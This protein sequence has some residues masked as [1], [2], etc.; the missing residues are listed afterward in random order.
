VQRIKADFV[1]LALRAPLV[2]APQMVRDKDEKWLYERIN[3]IKVAPQGICVLDSTGQVLIWVQ[4][5]ERK[6]DVLKFL[7]HAVKRYRDTAG[8]RAPVVTERYMRFPTDKMNDVPDE[9]AIPAHADRHPKGTRCPAA[10]AKGRVA[11]GTVVAHLVGR[12]LDD[13]G[14]PLADVVNQ[15]HYAED[16]FALEPTVQERLGRVLTEA[17]TDRVLLPEEFARMCATH[18]HLGHIDV[19]PCLCMVPGKHENPGEWKRCAF[20]AKR[21][22]PEAGVWRLDG[23]SEVVSKVTVNG[24]G[25]HNVKLTWSGFITLKG[26]RVS[27]LLLSARGHEKLE[28]CKDLHPLIKSGKDEVAFL[29]GGRPIDVD[30][31]VRYGI[32]GEPIAAEEAIEEPAPAAGS[33]IPDEARRPL[34]EALGGPFIVFRDK[35]QEELKLSDDQK[36]KLLQEFPNH[37]QATMKVFEKIKDLQPPEREKEMQQHRRKSDEKLSAV[38]KDV[39]NAGQQERLLQLQLQQAGAFALLGQHEAFVPLKITD[40][41]RRQFME[42]VQEMHKKI[43]PVIK[44]VEKGGKPE[45]IRPRVMKI[46]KEHEA[47][48][49]ELLTEKQKKQWKDLLGKPFDLG[50]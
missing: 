16:K 12:L 18:A 31:G 39:L 19:Q 24:Q 21:A 1:P 45:E 4:M 33:D 13:K 47:K 14:K 26:N 2:N 30:S 44:E 7:D 8:A 23:E 11:P 22:G 20:W 5:F 48:I 41:Q 25:V 43:E 40:E 34:V 9:T 10:T 50:E 49:E 35:V 28:F 38:L 27:Q 29:P 46:R 32:I 36:Q 37:V 6:E 42:V 17:G 3:R 15:E